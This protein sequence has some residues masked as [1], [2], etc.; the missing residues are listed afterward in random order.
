MAFSFGL[1]LGDG[2]PVDPPTFRSSAGTSWKVGDDVLYRGQEKA[3]VVASGT[4]TPTSRRGSSSKN[5]VAVPSAGGRA[6][7]QQ[8]R[9]PTDGFSADR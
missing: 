4:T 2:A 7:I 5:G 3:P 6:V 1:E 9:P 8:A